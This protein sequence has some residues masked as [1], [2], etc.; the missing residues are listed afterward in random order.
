MTASMY[1]WLANP[2]AE[3]GLHIAEDTGGW[4]FR[5]YQELAADARAR[6]GE[7][8]AAGVRD[9]DVVCVV[10]PTDFACVSTLFAVWAAGGTICPVVPP[11]FS[12]RDRYVHHLS[13]IV[14]KAEPAAVVTNDALTPLVRTAL[15]D[16]ACPVE[17]LLLSGGGADREPRPPADVALLQF[18][19]GSTGNP[20]GV[21]VT[22]DNLVANVTAVRRWLRMRADEGVASW[23]P[24]YHDMGLIGCLLVPVTGQHHLWLLRPDQFIREPARWI[25]CFGDGR[26]AHTAAP[27]F[28]YG[29]AA[30]RLRP[31][32]L[33][34]LDFSGWHNAIVGAEHVDTTTVDTFVRL[35]R[36]HGFAAGTFAPAYGLAEATLAVTGRPPGSVAPLARIRSDALRFGGKVPVEARSA[37]GEERT[38]GAGWLVGCGT[39]RGD[40]QVSVV[41]EDRRPLPQA[42][43]G[44]IT[45]RGPSVADGYHKAATSDATSFADGAVYTGDAGFLLDGTLYVAGRMGD[46]FK[47][48]GR[49]VYVEDL[50]AKVVAETGLSR[51]RCVVVGAGAGDDAGVTVV[52]ETAEGQWAA[53]AVAVLERELGRDRPIKVLCGRTGVIPRTSSGKPRRRIMWQQLQE[54]SL[55]VTVVAQLPGPA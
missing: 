46:S 4:V 9:G 30:R 10:L 38:Q 33:D 25:R 32:D 22:G 12:D 15:A 17:P 23:L 29:Y 18:T 39:P 1:D 34:G 47:I 35:L 3:H 40:A 7:L 48:R 8:R 20:R 45:V 43:L 51:W 41:G 13:A 55:D 11:M 26:A 37:I 36:P 14:A 6:A 27:P 49:T 19:S 54:G 42:H 50:E 2:A 21:R 31:A 16:A 5:S 52:A 24:L 44:E 53:R 28:G